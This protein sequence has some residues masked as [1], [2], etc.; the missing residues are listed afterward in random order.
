MFV[1]ATCASN[2]FSFQLDADRAR[3]HGMD[4]FISA[5]PCKFAHHTLFR[6]LQTTALDYRLND[7]Y[8]SLVCTPMSMHVN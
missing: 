8:C 1:M 3:K 2:V 7:P 4:E 5:D 6:T